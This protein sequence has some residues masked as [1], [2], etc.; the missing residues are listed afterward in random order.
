MIW[1]TAECLP[2]DYVY[3][4]SAD[5]GEVGGPVIRSVHYLKNGDNRQKS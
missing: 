1:E 2:G 5:W 4:I 3:E